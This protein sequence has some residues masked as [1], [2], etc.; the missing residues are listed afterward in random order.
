MEQGKIGMKPP[1][2][3]VIK[4]FISYLEDTIKHN[5]TISI[6]ITTEKALDVL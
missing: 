3:I 4:R 2:V 1:S 6:A 5:M